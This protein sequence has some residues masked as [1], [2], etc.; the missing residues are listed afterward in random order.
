MREE[1]EEEEGDK[2]KYRNCSLFCSLIKIMGAVGGGLSIRIQIP[3]ASNEIIMNFQ[4]ASHFTFL[5]ARGFTF[6]INPAD[7]KQ[8][9]RALTSLFLLH[10]IV[11]K[12]VLLQLRESMEN[13]FVM[14]FDSIVE[15]LNL[16]SFWSFY[17]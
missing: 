7:T 2:K 14:N 1:I 17:H 16:L 11:I 10:S 8:H 6:G 3:W 15:S 9:Y 5:K 4:S 13:G 12:A